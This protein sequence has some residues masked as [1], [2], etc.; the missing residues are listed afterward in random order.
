M[1]CL[2]SGLFDDV[3]LIAGWTLD[4]DA[5]VR[6]SGIDADFTL[7]TVVGSKG[8]FIDIYSM[9]MSANVLR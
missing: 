9:E 5:L 1:N 6:S 2:R 3:E 8:A 4:L 7:T